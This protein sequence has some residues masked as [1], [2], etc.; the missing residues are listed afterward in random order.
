MA[1]YI[2]TARID[3]VGRVYWLCKVKG[4]EVELHPRPSYCD[5]G[6]WQAHMLDDGYPHN[7][8]PF[9]A[10][11]GFPRYYFDLDRAKAEIEAL[12]SFR[13]MEPV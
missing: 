5:R 2:W 7:Q 3:S 8:N 11:D 13:K 9:D 4:A 1:D 12:F 10:A 6:R